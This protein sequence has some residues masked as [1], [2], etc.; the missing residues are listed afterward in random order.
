MCVLYLYRSI[1]NDFKC[2]LHCDGGGKK[3]SKIGKKKCTSKI[4]CSKFYIAGNKYKRYFRIDKIY[5]VVVMIWLKAFY[6]Y[7]N[8]LMSFKLETYK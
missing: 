8:N 4:D 7:L 3:N 2:K 1:I 6:V 5:T